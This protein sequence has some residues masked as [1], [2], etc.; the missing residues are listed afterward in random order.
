M[1]NCK[2]KVYCDTE[3]QTRV[4]SKPVYTGQKDKPDKNRVRSAEDEERS[5]KVST[6]RSLAKIYDLARS[7]VWDWFITLTFS[8]DKVNRFDYDECVG[9]LSKWL[10]NLRRSAPDLKYLVVP[11]LHKDG[12]YHFHGLLA[13]TCGIDFVPSGHYTGG[14]MIYNIGQYKLGF[15]TA[16]KVNNNSAVTKY[17]TKYVTKDLVAHTKHKRRYWGSRNLSLPEEST[18]YLEDAMQDVFTYGLV[19]EV[20][21][22]TT[23]DYQVGEDSRKMTIFESAYEV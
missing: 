5:L 16:T 14:Q 18:Y 13:C 9:K 11:E 7:N 6:N 1:Y 21:H 12:A 10:N 23:V 2:V 19:Q 22:V 20:H 8:P 3:L 15:T 17:I 4:Y